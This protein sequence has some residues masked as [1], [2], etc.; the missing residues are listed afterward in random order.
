MQRDLTTFPKSDFLMLHWCSN[1]WQHI[2]TDATAI[3]K[4]FHES[5]NIL[6]PWQGRKNTKCIYSRVN[7][8]KEFLS[9]TRKHFRYKWN[10]KSVPSGQAQT[11]PRPTT[12]A[13]RFAEDRDGGRQKK[14]AWSKGEKKLV[15]EGDLFTSKSGCQHLYFKNKKM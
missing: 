7:R 10:Q 12:E 1:Q 4:V 6:G 11:C 13:L 9:Y 14:T 8:I 2:C 3:C 15:R 5:D